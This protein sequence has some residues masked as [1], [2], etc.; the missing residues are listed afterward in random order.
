MEGHDPQNVRRA[1]S[2]GNRRS[3]RP[4]CGFPAVA[5][6]IGRLRHAPTHGA[7]RRDARGLRNAGSEP[8]LVTNRSPAPLVLDAA[9]RVGLP[10]GRARAEPAQRAPAG[11][12]AVAD[13]AL[14][15]APVRGAAG[16]RARRPARE[17]P[18]DG[19]APVDLAV[20]G[21]GRDGHVAFDEPPA[22]LASGSDRSLAPETRADEAAA[23]G[24]LAQ[25]PT[26]ALTVGL[27]T[28]WRAPVLL[29]VV[30]DS[31]KV[32]ALHA[33]LEEPV[34]GGCSASHVHGRALGG[35]AEEERVGRAC[36][37]RPA[38]SPVVTP[39]RTPRGRCP[40]LLALGEAREVVVVSS[41]WHIRVRGSSPRTA[42]SASAC[43]TARRSCTAGGVARRSVVGM[44]TTADS[45]DLRGQAVDR[46][47]KQQDL[48]S[49]VLVYAMVSVLVWTIWVMTGAA[50]RGRLR[51]RRLGHRRRDERLRRVAV[52]SSPRAPRTA[53]ASCRTGRS[54]SRAC[55]SSTGG[56]A[57]AL[58][59]GPRHRECA[60]NRR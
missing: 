29:V 17:R 14:A 6:A 12:A 30:S 31:A 60:S 21:L 27:G 57:T 44:P 8:P 9:H 22:R 38:R 33:M 50:S 56:S 25:V 4:R 5:P 59:C 20:L 26:A 11:E 45:P 18:G 40:I 19:P 7:D 49:H 24:S 13:R 48:R 28:L 55:G 35:G 32:P 15:A 2:A 10:S 51:D 46:L 52:E 37:A 3:T 23:F 54:R 41:A 58:A 36:G 42:A 53:R 16:A 43:P 1:A 47:M 34:S 39:P